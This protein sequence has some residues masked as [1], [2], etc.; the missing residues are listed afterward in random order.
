MRKSTQAQI[1]TLDNLLLHIN[2]YNKKKKLACRREQKFI[3][4]MEFRWYTHMYNKLQIMIL[5]QEERKKN[6]ILFCLINVYSKNIIPNVTNK[7]EKKNAN[8]CVP[9]FL[10]SSLASLSIKIIL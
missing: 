10:Y 9:A 5:T 1:H 7:Q 3:I 6:V 4:M 2:A 8:T